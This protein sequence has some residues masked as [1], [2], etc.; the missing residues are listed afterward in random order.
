[1]EAAK[2]NFVRDTKHCLILADL[3]MQIQNQLF[4]PSDP[5]QTFVEK[6]KVQSHTYEKEYK[7]QLSTLRCEHDDIFLNIIIRWLLKTNSK[8]RQA[9]EAKVIK[10]RKNHGGEKVKI[11]QS[12]LINLGKKITRERARGRSQVKTKEE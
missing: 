5:N 1:M 7:I 2:V 9:V 11:L 12:M 4:S 8:G 3:K 6:A 10:W